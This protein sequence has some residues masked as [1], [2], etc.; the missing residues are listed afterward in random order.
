[1]TEQSISNENVIGEQKES[2]KTNNSFN[3]SNKSINEFDMNADES[4]R[5]NDSQ[6]NQ[7]K[8]NLSNKSTEIDMSVD[9]S[10]VLNDIRNIF[11]ISSEFII[12]RPLKSKYFRGSF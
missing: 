9:D 5:F 4:L 3:E 6:I 1:M 10:S 12:S 2:I 11:E 7:L 8:V